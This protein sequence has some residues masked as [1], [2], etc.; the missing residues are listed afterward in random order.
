ML[1]EKTKGR[2]DENSAYV[3]LFEN[4]DLG[5][6][7]SKIHATTISNGSELER[8]ILEKANKIE[9]LDA[10]IDDV[11]EAKL[12]SG[13]FL[14]AKRNIKKSSYAVKENLRMEKKLALSLIS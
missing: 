12:D 6:L 2:G 5:K 4:I 9:N 14:C 13:V 11:I 7:L 8:I 10:F 3:R 1:I